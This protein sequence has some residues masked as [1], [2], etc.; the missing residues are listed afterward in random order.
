MKTRNIITAAAIM[1]TL[2]TTS[3]TF[4]LPAGGN[5][6]GNG[7]GNDKGPVDATF[8]AESVSP[9]IPYVTS[10]SADAKGQIVYYGAM[11]LSQ[12]LGSWDS[13]AACGHLG[14]REG[15]VVIY[16]ESSRNPGKAEL[17]FWF[18][19]QLASGDSVTH[20]LTMRG[21]FDE[22][23]NWP[24]SVDDPYTSITLNEWEYAAENKKAQR[25]DCSGVS[26]FPAGPWTVNVTRLP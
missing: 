2:A 19:A 1:I 9:P 11:D 22:P 21:T 4:A 6:G 16:P 5:G 17:I 3:S 26:D 7:G 23:A 25:Q 24:P 15:I 8:T 14:L 13:G 12:F 20:L 10:N 18:N